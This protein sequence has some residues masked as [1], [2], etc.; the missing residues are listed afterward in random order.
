[1]A[2]DPFGRAKPRRLRRVLLGAAAVVALAA[3]A[4]PVFGP[5]IV[6]D[7][8]NPVTAAQPWHVSDEAARRQ[9]IASKLVKEIARL[10]G[11]VSK[12]V[13]PPVNS[14]LRARFAAG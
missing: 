2:R 12:F 4:V 3:A 10:G 11:D 8:L 6:A 14:A 7:R 1:M 13:T 9:A 5:R